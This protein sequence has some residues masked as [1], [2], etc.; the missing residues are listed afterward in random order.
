MKSAIISVD[1]SKRIKQIRKS[2]IL[3][4]AN[5]KKYR[6][7]QGNGF[8]NVLSFKEDLFSYLDFEAIV[9]SAATQDIIDLHA[10]I[11]K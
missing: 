6:D 8:K 11:N 4:L 7:F 3:T 5:I 9:F 2:T 10:I 1:G